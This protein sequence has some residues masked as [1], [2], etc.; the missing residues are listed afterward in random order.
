MEHR[1]VLGSETILYDIVKM[2]TW[3]YAPVN[4]QMKT[5][6]QKNS[7]YV[8]SFTREGTREITFA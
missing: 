7:Q 6:K 5:N 8:A 2:D 1:G 3:H 4:K